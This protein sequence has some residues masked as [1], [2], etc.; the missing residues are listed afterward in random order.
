LNAE[1]KRNSFTSETATK[2][3]FSSVLSKKS[4]R[5]ADSFEPIDI[6]GQKD[7]GIWIHHPGSEISQIW[8]PRKGKTRR[9]DTEI[10]GEPNGS[11][12]I[13]TEA[14]SGSS[15]N[16]TSS[17][18]E[19]PDDN[20]SMK[21][22]RRGLKKIGSV[23]HRSPKN[24]DHT[25]NFVEAVPSPHIN[26][27]AVNEKEIGVTFVVDDDHHVPASDKNSKE[28]SASLDGN[29]PDSPSKGNMKDMAKSFLKQAGKSARGIK[30]ALSRKGSK[31][32]R[33]ETSVGTERESSLAESDSSDDESNCSPGAEGITIEG[34]PVTSKAADE[35]SC[36]PGAERI[37]IEQIPVTPKAISSGGGN[38]SLNSEELVVQTT[39]DD[40]INTEGPKENES[41]Q[42]L[43]RKYD[44]KGNP[45]SHGD[46]VEESLEPK[47]AGVDLEGEKR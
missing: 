47:L 19:N 8:E 37:R 42:E 13:L 24:E 2:G 26:I 10:H 46:E 30:H 36:S 5:V 40:G 43:D 45:N 44:K 9:I 32:S 28:E 33:G 4:Q 3:S 7:T 41:L 15:K 6:E 38:N 34:I 23:F 20:R 21:S 25:D 18:D 12:S 14:A 1:D 31:T 39:E 29:G 22:V 27:R 16:D 17:T 11:M 35:S